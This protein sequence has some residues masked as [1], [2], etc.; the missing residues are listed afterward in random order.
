MKLIIGLGNPGEKYVNTRH[1]VGFFLCDSLEESKTGSSFVIKKSDSFMNDS[2]GFVQKML[3]KYKVKPEDL[4]IVHDDLDIKLGDYKI[5]FGKGPK[6]H[7]GINSVEEKISTNNFWRVRIGVDNR[8]LDNRTPG[9]EY[10]L[11]D[12]TPQEVE[13][14]NGVL[15]EICK[16]LVTS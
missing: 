1:N 7:N 12:F 2:G 8:D 14:V 13:T 6:V 16:K 15:K 9:E 4:Y 10:V 3:N 5:Q 11:Q